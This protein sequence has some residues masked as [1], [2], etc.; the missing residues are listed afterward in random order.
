MIIHALRDHCKALYLAPKFETPELFLTTP[1][2]KIMLLQQKLRGI[3]LVTTLVFTGYATAKT[4]LWP[5]DIPT[6]E[7]VS[8]RIYAEKTAFNKNQDKQYCAGNAECEKNTNEAKTVNFF[9]DRC[10][11]DKDAYYIG[12]NGKEYRLKRTGGDAKKEPYLTGKFSGS[13][14]VVEIKSVKLIKK[15][16]DEGSKTDVVDAEYEVDVNITKGKDKKQI[17]AV[18][19]FGV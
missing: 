4:E 14:F 9:T 12:I 18:L 2:E 7:C 1:E 5:S 10:G 11:L 16:F 13:G 8:S 19:W 3:V 6:G 15:I 17:K